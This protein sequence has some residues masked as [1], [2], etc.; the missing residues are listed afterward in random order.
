MN[1]SGSSRGTI[2]VTRQLSAAW[3]SATY[4]IKQMSGVVKS[5]AGAVFKPGSHVDDL[6][7]II[8]EPIVLQVPERRNSGKPNLY[9]VLTG[10]LAVEGPDFRAPLKTRTFATRVAYFRQRH[11]ELEHVFGIHYDMD[12]GR[13]DHPVFHAQVCPLLGL[14]G[15]ACEAFN[16]TADITNAMGPILRNVRMPS[17]QMDIFAAVT[18]VC[19]DHLLGEGSGDVEQRAFDELRKNCDTLVGAA[20]RLA[21]LNGALAA[22]CYRSTHWYDS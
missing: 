13:S 22:G 1:S 15:H 21:F 20:H 5:T 3:S 12:E 10:R 8:V 7:E 18:Q 19:A 16:L 9:V 11:G 14:G 17:A 2:L 4:N 6:V